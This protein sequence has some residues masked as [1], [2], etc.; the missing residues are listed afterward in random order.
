MLINVALSI[1]GTDTSSFEA[2][3]G[4]IARSSAVIDVFAISP[5]SAKYCFKALSKS[6]TIL[7]LSKSAIVA[8]MTFVDSFFCVPCPGA[9]VE[10]LFMS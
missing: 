7:F 1:D 9:A 10:V 4:C 8:F 6:T 3:L 2:I 5:A